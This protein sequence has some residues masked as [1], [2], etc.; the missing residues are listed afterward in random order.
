MV[1]VMPPSGGVEKLLATTASPLVCGDAKYGPFPELE[2]ARAQRRKA[3]GK[4][5]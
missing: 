3:L 4:T 2:Q 5:D 1:Q